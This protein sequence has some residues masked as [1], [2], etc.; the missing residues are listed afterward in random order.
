MYLEAEQARR[1]LIR[2]MENDLNEFDKGKSEYEETISMLEEELNHTRLLQT[3]QFRTIDQLQKTLLNN[4]LAVKR[5]MA[6]L[7]NCKARDHEICPLSLAPINQSPLPFGD[8]TSPCDLVLNP[9][10]PDYKCAQL[11]CGHRFNAIW[12]IYHFIEGDTFRCPVCRAGEANFR[13]LRSELP[14]AVL[15]M[16]ELMEAAK[17]KGKAAKK[18]GTA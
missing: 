17:K 1:K 8:N 18:K 5:S 11:V 9:L 3:T 16:L 13:F 12:L 10:K 2:K 7:T 4:G 14:P 6:S 15:K